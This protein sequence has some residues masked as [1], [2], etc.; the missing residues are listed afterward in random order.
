LASEERNGGF[1]P[2]RSILVKQ[3]LREFRSVVESL[4]PEEK[5]QALQCMVKQITVLP[6]KL[7]MDVYEL[8]D[9]TKGS[10]NR[11]N[12]LQRKGSETFT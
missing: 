1:E 5:T 4:T 10:S 6:D 2:F 12:W 8:A 9:F 7:L 11:S 3:N